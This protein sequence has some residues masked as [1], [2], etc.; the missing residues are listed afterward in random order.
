M[1]LQ[2]LAVGRLKAGPERDLAERY[3]DRI[4][5]GVRGLGLSG[6]DVV[7][8]S[9]S[10]AR[11]AE[12]RQTEESGLLRLRAENSVLVLFHE[13]AASATSED[14]AARLAGWRD[15]GRAAASFVI[16]GPDGL[17]PALEAEAGAALSF[18]RLTL[19]HALV[20][21]LVLEQ[22]YRATTILS[23]HPYHRGTPSAAAG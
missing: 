7:E 5:A 1:R 3:R 2:V 14:F 4:A 23:G 18:G 8:L 19:P 12:D 22:L 10:R 20:R 21:I 16:G 9:E 6:P 13:R 11:R 17:S 15:R